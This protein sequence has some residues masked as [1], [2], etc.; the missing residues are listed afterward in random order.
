MFTIN[1]VLY[2]DDQNI[3]LQSRALI[4]SQLDSV[5]DDDQDPEL[6]NLIC[7][8]TLQLLIIKVLC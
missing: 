5:C 1:S 3:N 4:L 8:E 6:Q 2:L 7:L